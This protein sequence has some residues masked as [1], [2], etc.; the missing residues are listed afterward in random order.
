M[1]RKKLPTDR[2]TAFRLCIVECTDLPINNVAMCS[3]YVGL[4][5]QITRLEN[6]WS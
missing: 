4:T 6:V 2:Q 5:D 3:K 1:C